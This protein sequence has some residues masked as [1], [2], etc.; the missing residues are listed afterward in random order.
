M[1]MSDIDY[2]TEIFYEEIRV[3]C[4]QEKLLNIARCVNLYDP[5]S[6]YDKMKYHRNVIEMS[7]LAKSKFM[8][9]NNKQYNKFKYFYFKKE[10]LKMLFLNCPQPLIQGLLNLKVSKN[11]DYLKSI[12]PNDFFIV[13][14]YTIKKSLVNT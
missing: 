1:E 6:K 3:N 4:N 12:I 8:I 11:E 13:I 5:I 9:H 7:I 14:I 10:S 2:N